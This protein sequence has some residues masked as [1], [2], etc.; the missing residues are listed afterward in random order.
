[1][2]RASSTL[3]LYW[4][5]DWWRAGFY[6]EYFLKDSIGGREC[7]LVSCY[8]LING[9]VEGASGTCSLLVGFNLGSLWLT[10]GLACKCLLV[11]KSV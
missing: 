6:L 3:R 2:D 9:G 5:S 11:G 1:M 10:T 4:L 8:K 7:R